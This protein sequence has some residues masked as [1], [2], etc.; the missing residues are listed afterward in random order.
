MSRRMRRGLLAA[1]VTGCLV[2]AL[3]L[4]GASS[5]SAADG[6]FTIDGNVPDAGAVEL[7]DASGNIKE[8]GPENGSTTKIG[9]IHA[10]DEPTLGLTNPNAQVDLR[11][12][13][14]TTQREGDKDWLYFAWE[15]DSNNGSGFIAFEFMQNKAPVE[16]D[17][18]GSSNAELIA[19]CNPWANRAAGDFIILWDQQ[20][21]SRQLWLRTWSGTA[22]N[23]VLSGAMPLDLSVSQAEYGA[24]GSRGEAAV[25]L[26]DTVF[27]GTT[28]CRA[29][30]NV[31]PSTVTGNS[32]TADYKDTVLQPAPAL[33]N[34]TT[35]TVT[36]PTLGDGGAISGAGVPIGTGAVAVKDS[37]VITLEGGSSP[38]SG[39]VDFFLCKVDAP[40]LCTTD[41]TEVGSTDVTGSFPA[42]VE[43]PTAYVTAAG[44]YCWR[45]VYSGDTTTGI[46]GSTDSRES[47]CFTVQPAT[48]TLT[49]AAGDDVLLGEGVTDTAT[50]M[51]TVPQPADPVINLTGET[52]PDAAGTI[53]FMLYGPSGDGCGSLVDTTAAVTVDGDGDYGTPDPQIVPDVP[54]DYHWV[55]TYSGSPNTNGVTHNEE[56]DDESEDVMVQT[57]K[58]S[59]TTAQTWVPNDSVMLTAPAGGAMEGTVHIALFPNATCDDGDDPVYEDDLAV[60]GP[61]GQTVTTDN[62]TAVSVSGDYSWQVSYTST[63]LA[64]RDI[65]ASCL[66]TSSL[67]ISNGGEAISD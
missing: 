4:A 33:G 15:R 48:P 39:S 31:I 50:L 25:N 6:P 32:D 65:G 24:N 52:G 12:A 37:A 5:A 1:G 7:P 67:Q 13:W 35:T 3:M 54:G 60:P 38:A 41:G 27:G 20:G 45:A 51:G 61:D 66:E 43:S 11:R 10:D 40:G 26:T 14:I 64:Q 58:S 22:P 49:T 36:T 17:Y 62:T 29:F 16:C 55:A 34:C 21:N 8:L 28:S 59:L 23:L 30:A 47:E 9:V 44:R 18:L 57:V 63:N 53:T 2:A 56:C 42:T 19:G 46:G